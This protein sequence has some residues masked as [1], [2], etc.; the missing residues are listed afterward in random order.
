MGTIKTESKE[1]EIYWWGPLLIRFK[2]S[3]ETRKLFLDEANKST[4][5]NSQDLAGILH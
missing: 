1:Y 2:I 4:E 5:E 3:E